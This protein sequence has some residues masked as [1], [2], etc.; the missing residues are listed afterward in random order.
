MAS[1]QKKIKITAGLAAVKAVK[2][3]AQKLNSSF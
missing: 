3:N 1:R 2:M